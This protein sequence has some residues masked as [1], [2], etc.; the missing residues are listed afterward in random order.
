MCSSHQW[1]FH[2]HEHNN[3]L[4]TISGKVNQ[5]LDEYARK[6]FELTVSKIFYF[7]LIGLYRQ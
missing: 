3:L 7:N 6:L 2:F 1:C 5:R 4:N